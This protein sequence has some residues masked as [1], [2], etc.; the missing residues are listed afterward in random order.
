MSIH[1]YVRSA[2]P[3]DI[4]Q[5]LDRD[6]DRENLPSFRELSLGRDW[7]A[8]HFLLTGSVSGGRGPRAFLK[9]GGLFVQ[10]G[11]NDRLFRPFM[12][13]RIHAALTALRMP[14]I[15]PRFK[16]HK[17]EKAGVYLGSWDYDPPHEGELFDLVKELKAFVRGASSRGDWLTYADDA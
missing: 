9:S 17:M 13:R 1:V 3:A 5:W 10:R 8:L 16:P 6:E 11:G 12:V 4:R 7:D 15:R 2:S 14:L